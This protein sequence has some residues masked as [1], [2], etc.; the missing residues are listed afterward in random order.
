MEREK[1]LQGE[2][3]ELVMRMAHLDS[4]GYD[5]DTVT[6]ERDYPSSIEHKAGWMEGLNQQILDKGKEVLS[7]RTLPITQKQKKKVYE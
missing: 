2:I 3:L 4:F 5:F 7:L 1:E 6:G